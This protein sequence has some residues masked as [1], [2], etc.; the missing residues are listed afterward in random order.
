MLDH[1]GSSVCIFSTGLVI[2]LPQKA[3]AARRVPLG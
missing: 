3:F 1:T 2:Y